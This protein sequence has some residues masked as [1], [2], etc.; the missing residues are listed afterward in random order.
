MK[1]ELT[2]IPMVLLAEPEEAIRESIEMILIDE[3]YDCH[4]VSNTQ[5][6]MQAISIH[7]SDLIIA[8]VRIIYE[9]I[10]DIVAAQNMYGDF[11]PFLVTLTYEQVRDM[12][13]LMRYG[14]TEYLIKPFQFDDMTSRIR[15]IIDEQPSRHLS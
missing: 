3:G 15:H 7:N 1:R 12:L 8:D 14:I 2:D 9:S 4:P 13:Y 10:E 5:A 11:P 6:L